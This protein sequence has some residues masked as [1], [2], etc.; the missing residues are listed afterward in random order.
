MCLTSYL[1]AP[2]VFLSLLLTSH[3]TPFNAPPSAELIFELF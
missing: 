1:T 2:L 3:A